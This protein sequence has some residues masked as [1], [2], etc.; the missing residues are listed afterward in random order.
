M[1]T[2]RADDPKSYRGLWRTCFNP[3]TTTCSEPSVT[4]GFSSIYPTEG[5]RG[6][7]KGTSLALVGVSNGAVQ[8]MA[9]EELKQWGFEQKRKRFAREGKPMTPEDDKLV[10]VTRP[11][12]RSL[13]YSRRHAQSN[14]AYTIMSGG[15]KLFALAMTYPYQVIR[16]RLQV[17]PVSPFVRPTCLTYSRV[18]QNN[19]TTHLYPDIPTTIK[20]TWKG[21]GIQ[22]FYRGL[23][24]N[25][26]RVLPGTCVTFVV[27]E[28]LAWL[29]RTTALRRQQTREKSGLS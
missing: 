22:G 21:E 29:F 15:S 10:R 13:V 14:T 24:T 16:S 27:Y 3:I 11:D 4:D 7:W 20:R 2:T 18:A 25:F 12:A 9:Y 28:N 23:G 1:F 6:L 8:F 17:G 26:V 5:I 19:A